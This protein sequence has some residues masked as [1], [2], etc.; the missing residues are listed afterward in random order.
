MS[1]SLTKG[2]KCGFDLTVALFFALYKANYAVL[3]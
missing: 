1:G 2:R 3:G